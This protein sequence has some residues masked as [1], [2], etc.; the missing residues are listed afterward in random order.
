MK[1]NTRF[2]FNESHFKEISD[3]VNRQILAIYMAG[4]HLNN[5]DTPDSDFDYVVVTKPNVE[6]LVDG[7]HNGSQTKGELDAKV[8]SLFHFVS[9]IKKSNPNIVE[10][11][12]RFPLYVDEDFEPF[13]HY[14]HYNSDKIAKINVDRLLKSCQ[15]TMM[16]N[17]KKLKS[18]DKNNGKKMAQIYKMAMYISQILLNEPLEKA[19]FFEELNTRDF[20]KRFKKDH[21]NHDFEDY[22]EIMKDIVSQSDFL[23]SVGSTKYPKGTSFREDTWSEL[24]EELTKLL[25]E[26]I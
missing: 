3:K 25:R 8:Y 15:G 4:S 21:F 7:N 1:Y 13:A 20:M 23:V 19:V 24:M 2:E 10:L 9:L 18:E 17:L 5:L 6:D 12:Y 11:L 22:L 14:L 26:I 16:S